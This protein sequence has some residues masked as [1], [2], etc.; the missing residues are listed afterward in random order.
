MGI[1]KVLFGKKTNKQ[2]L[3]QLLEEGAIIVD[4]RTKG[5][6]SSGYINGSENFPLQDISSKKDQILAMKKV[7]FC[8]ASGLRSAQATNYFKSKGLVCINGG[9]WKTVNELV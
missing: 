2:V 1:L 4:V 6:Y 7:I 8:C 5:E 9:S 3:K